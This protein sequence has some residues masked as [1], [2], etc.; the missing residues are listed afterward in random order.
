MNR[1]TSFFEQIDREYP[2]V[3]LMIEEWCSINSWSQNI[4]GLK[5]LTERLKRDFASL[6]ECFEIPLSPWYRFNQEGVP[7]SLPLGTALSIIKRRQTN[8]KILFCGHMDTV[9]PP[10]CLFTNCH[11]DGKERLVGPGVADMKGGLGILLLALTIF[12]KSPHAGQLGWEI[13]INPDEEI[14]SIS[15][16]KH[17]EERA[18]YYDLGLLFEPAFPDGSIVGERK[19]S[20]NY[21]ILAKGKAAHVGRDFH[22]GKNAISALASF[23]TKIE[24]LQGCFEGLTINIGY[25]HGG[26]PTNI[27]PDHAF[28][29]MNI[30]FS[31][32]TDLTYIEQKLKEFRT[33]TLHSSGA[34]I[35]I[36]QESLRLPK[37][38]DEKTKIIYQQ[39]KE[40][41]NHL[42]EQLVLRSTGGVCDGNTLA[43]AGLPNLDT[44]G[45]VGGNIHTKEEFILVESIRQR[46]K[47]LFLYLVNFA[48]MGT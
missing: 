20:A 48:Q 44:L 39:F 17:L 15:S 9:F 14:G 27:V 26:G 42:N 13:F 5:K 47:L 8:K 22:S 18:T 25:V 10:N 7:E 19:G 29:R 38:L 28:G 35:D 40:C 46:A 41:A 3:L 12:E 43:N 23:V 2:R 6:G 34:M 36:H 31:K 45:A 21:A 11:K 1:L 16:K 30:R 4:S 37:V 33:E 24:K 32:S